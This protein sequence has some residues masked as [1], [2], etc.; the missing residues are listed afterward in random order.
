MQ[1]L[2]LKLDKQVLRLQRNLLRA[3]LNS[4]IRVNIQLTTKDLI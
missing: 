1:D 4:N 3:T 2:L